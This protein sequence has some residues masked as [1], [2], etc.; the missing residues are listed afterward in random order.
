VSF[1]LSIDGSSHARAAHVSEWH[2]ASSKQALGY[3]EAGDLP[4]GSF[5]YFSGAAGEAQFANKK[6]TQAVPTR[7]VKG[8]VVL[9]GETFFWCKLATAMQAKS[10]CKSGGIGDNDIAYI[11]VPPQR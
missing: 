4:K 3:C 7:K 6:C 8:A 10:L 11:S 2:L 1:L 5:A 9:A